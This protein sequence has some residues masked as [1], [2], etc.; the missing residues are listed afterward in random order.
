MNSV[1]LP[2]QGGEK[3]IAAHILQALRTRAALRQRPH[4]THA[5][6]L[7]AVILKQARLE[8]LA[9]TSVTLAYTNRDLG[10]STPT[11]CS[12][13]MGIFACLTPWRANPQNYP[14]RC[15]RARAHHTYT[16]HSPPPPPPHPVRPHAPTFTLD[17]DFG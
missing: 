2:A 3:L 15:T 12:L 13:R 17:M 14:T 10:M 7:D 8:T 16:T 1:R 4:C 11:G 5:H 6:A 9:P